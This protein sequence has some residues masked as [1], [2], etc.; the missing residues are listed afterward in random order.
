MANKA[1]TTPAL[2]YPTTINTV[3]DVQ[4]YLTALL[5]SLINELRE[6]AYRLNIVVAGDGTET[7][8]GPVIVPTY[9]KTALPDPVKYKDGLITVSNEAGGYV[10]AF[11][12]GAVWRR[13][14]DRGMVS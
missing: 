11:S 12:D 3:T 1:N 8:T 14:T 9:V 5:I 4:I 6:H 7:P 13:V 2:P 10:L